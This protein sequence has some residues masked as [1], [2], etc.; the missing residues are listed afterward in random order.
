MNPLERQAAEAGSG[1][2]R[3]RHRSGSARPEADS[4]LSDADGGSLLHCE[5]VPLGVPCGDVVAR[6]AGG[7]EWDGL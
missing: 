6:A 5:A 3:W 4:G 1:G 7:G 2:R